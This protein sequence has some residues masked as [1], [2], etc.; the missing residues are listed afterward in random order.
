MNAIMAL[1]YWSQRANAPMTS[2][3]EPS[4]GPPSV[5]NE[6]WSRGDSSVVPMP[7]SMARARDQGGGRDRRG[8]AG[9]RWKRAGAGAAARGRLEAGRA[10]E[11][12]GRADAAA[13]VGAGPEG[14][15]ARR[16]DRRLAAGA[17]ARRA[18][19]IVG[20]V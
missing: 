5:A 14:R 15:A 1:R 3:A 18:R 9:G 7:F 20:I 6:R 17:A 11:M 16:D 19:Q 8:G 13:G 4:A 12:R 10:A 2:A